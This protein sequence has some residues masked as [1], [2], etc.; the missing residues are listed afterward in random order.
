MKVRWIGE[1]DIPIITNGK[2]YEV[3]SVEIDWYRILDDTNDDYLYPPELFE[4]VE[5]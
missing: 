5:E 3:I 1:T 2:I 4:I